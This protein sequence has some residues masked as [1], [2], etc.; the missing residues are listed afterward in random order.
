MERKR[1]AISIAIAIYFIVH[2]AFYIIASLFIKQIGVWS[3]WYS[4]IFGNITISSII[5]L[6]VIFGIAYIATGLGI[7]FRQHW[8]RIALM[9]LCTQAIFFEF[10]IGMMLSIFILIYSFFTASFSSMFPKKIKKAPYFFGGIGIIVICIIALL[11]VTGAATGFVKFTQYQVTGFGLSSDSPES[12]ID[13]I[14]QRVGLIDVLIELTGSPEY[15]SEQQDKFIS[16]ASQYINTIESRIVETSN[17]L[18]VNMEASDLLKIAENNNVAK[19][20]PVEA[21]FQFLPTDLSGALTSNFAPIQLNVEELQSS[22]ITGK[23]ITI[24]IMDTGIKEDHPDLQRDGKSIVVG[25]LHLHGEYVYSHGTMVASC[26]ANQNETWKGIAP[27]V[28]LLN[29]EVFSWQT[30]GGVQYLTAT[31]ADILKGFE[32]VANW[33]KITGDYVILSCSWGV[34]AQ[35]WPHDANTAIAAANRL[36]VEYNIPVIAAAGNSGPGNRAEYTSIPFQM[37]SPAGGKNVLS[38]GAVDSSNTVATFSSRG[39]YY[40]GLGKPDVVAPGV[41]VPVLDYSGITSASGTSFACP[42]V[43]GVA[44]LLAQDHRDLSSLQLY[45]AIRSGAVDLGI[46]GYDYEYGYGIV[47]AEKSISFI[48]QSVSSQNIILLFLVLLAVGA[49]VMV[50]PVL[51]KKL[52]R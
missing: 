26:I 51:N 6:S 46:E 1:T 2:G 21:S 20:Y 34:S 49:I 17:A 29:I 22:G 7:I 42:Y 10:P 47:D 12:K 27:D 4:F 19:I 18:I 23:G 5:L 45:D 28:D 38:V 32:F 52:H 8:A 9:I 14:E 44:A 30:V 3:S 39:P 11:V 15:A 48:E 37:M 31:N 25:S 16:E 36:A 13:S 33:K 43:S 40:D 50:Y 35:T 41:D 24:A